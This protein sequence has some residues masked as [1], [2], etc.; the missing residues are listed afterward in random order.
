MARA[1]VEAQGVEEALCAALT[2][3]MKEKPENA[4]ASLVGKLSAKVN[5]EKPAMC[6]F[7]TVDKSKTVQ[8]YTDVFWR[9]AY[10]KKLCATRACSHPFLPTHPPSIR[11]RCR[12]SLQRHSC[13]SG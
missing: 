9:H 12:P 3:V 13:C 2:E 8:E 1:Y 4:L 6:A 10:Y 11:L 5:A 7:L